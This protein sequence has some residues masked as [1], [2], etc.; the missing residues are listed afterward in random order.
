MTNLARWC[1]VFATTALALFADDF[2]IKKPFTAWSDKEASKLLTNSPWSHSVVFGGGAIDEP[3]RAVSGG[4][5]AA[6]PSD[7]SMTGAAIGAGGPANPGSRPDGNRAGGELP[8]GGRTTVPITVHVRWLSARPVRQALVIAK[9]G[10]ER[11][12]SE[13]ARKFLEQ[14]PGYYVVA[15][16]GLPPRM[17]AALSEDRLAALAKTAMLLRKDK[18]PIAAESAQR[19]TDE[20]GV[21]F[22]FPKTLPI[23]LDD[24]EVEFVSKAGAIE[25]KTKFKLKDMMLARKLEL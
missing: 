20:P 25:L 10:R 17:A 14:S 7:D 9:L 5:P 22:L 1:F 18:D 15:V 11:V 6:S 8:R 19:L 2:W 23:T 21:A 12:D 16:A 4:N 13:Q 24:K 3:G